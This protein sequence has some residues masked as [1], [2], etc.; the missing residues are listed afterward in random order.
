MN[1]PKSSG[2]LIGALAAAIVVAIGI[3]GAL[4]RHF[5]TSGNSSDV[6]A[7]PSASA[8]A[9]A[10]PTQTSYKDGT[11]SEA[12]SYSTPGGIERITVTLT[13]AGGVVTAADLTQQVVSG[14]AQQYQSQ[15]AAGYK[16]YVVGK[17]IDSISLTRVSGSSL[18]PAGFMNAL[19][20]IKKD[21]A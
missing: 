5:S 9:D 1:A 20:A 7:T 21:A 10:S 13:V 14:T 4:S 16:T 19:A 8:P 15:F 11:Y 6:V 2:P 18:T 3:V 12:G 17:S